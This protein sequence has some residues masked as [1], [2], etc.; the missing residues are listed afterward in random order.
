M[1]TVYDHEGAYLGCMGVR[2]WEW[3]RELSGM[4][5]PALVALAAR[6]DELERDFA[7]LQDFGA[8]QMLRAERAEKVVAAARRAWADDSQFPAL[9]AALREYDARAVLGEQPQE[10]TGAERRDSLDKW[11]AEAYRKS[12]TGRIYVYKCDHCRDTKVVSGMGET[13]PCPKC[14]EHPQ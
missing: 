2:T 6:A 4:D 10:T 14:Q 8:K 11:I 5:A 7:K 12:K 1:V 13:V 3:L 9:V